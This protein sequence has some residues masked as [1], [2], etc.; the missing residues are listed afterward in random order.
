MKICMPFS[1][2]KIMNLYNLSSVFFIMTYYDFTK[3]LEVVL[4][5][6][7]CWNEYMLEKAIVSLELTCPIL[8]CTLLIS[9][10][11]RF[12]EMNMVC[13][14]QILLEQLSVMDLGPIKISSTSAKTVK[15]LSYFYF[16]TIEDKD[17]W[18]REDAR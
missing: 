3:P 14:N 12:V 16:A 7:F 17:K 2:A 10:H 9:T 11:D 4:A 15:Y 13:I 1:N 8:F 5:T 6:A 18:K